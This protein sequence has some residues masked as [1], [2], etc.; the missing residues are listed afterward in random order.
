MKNTEAKSDEINTGA[1]PMVTVAV[2]D[3]P[4]VAGL[5]KS[6]LESYDIPVFLADEYTIGVNSLYAKHWCIRLRCLKAVQKMLAEFYGR[7]CYRRRRRC[8]MILKH[9]AH[10]S[11]NLWPG[12]ICCWGYPALLASS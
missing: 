7:N 10:L 1:E 11:P 4:Y 6:E 8:C 12:S 3:T 9:P 5:A 2:Y